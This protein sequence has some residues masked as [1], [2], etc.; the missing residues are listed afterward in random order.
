MIYG[1]RNY[2]RNVPVEVAIGIEEED[3]S[4]R[5]IGGPVGAIAKHTNLYVRLTPGEKTS[6]K[7]AKEIIYTLAKKASD[8]ERK[9]ILNVP[10][11]EVQRFIP[12]GRGEISS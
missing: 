3:D 1:E 5:V 6:S 2:V 4:A 8:D 11:E 9:D 10:I 7:L 12:L